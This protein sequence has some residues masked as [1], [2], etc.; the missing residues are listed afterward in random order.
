MTVKPPSGA[1]TSRLIGVD[2][3]SAFLGPARADIEQER[4][5]AVFDLLE[6]NHFKLLDGPPGPYRLR[7]AMQDD[8]LSF[9]VSDAG[10]G[11]LANVTI[12]FGSFKRLVRD[13]RLVCLS[14]YDAI[15]T[16]PP[17]RIEA[18]DMGRRALHD[19][20]SQLLIERLKNR[21]EVDLP[22]ARRLFTLICALH[23]RA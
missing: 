12:G 14:Y 7:L 20:A 3:D 6:V 9:D 15:R 10:A 11:P 1:D 16:A 13:Y 18:I 23:W 17:S 19:E 5:V 2:L 8:R 22:T 4:S 21:I